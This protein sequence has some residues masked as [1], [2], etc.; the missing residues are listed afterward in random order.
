MNA[1]GYSERYF[2]FSNI[3]VNIKNFRDI[4][5]QHKN[6]TKMVLSDKISSKFRQSV[7]SQ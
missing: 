5:N 1:V 7:K 4:G 3:I 2:C 6:R